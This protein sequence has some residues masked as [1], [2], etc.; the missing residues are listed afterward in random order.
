MGAVPGVEDWGI[1]VKSRVNHLLF[2]REEGP[3]IPLTPIQELLSNR[4]TGGPVDLP[5][6][7]LKLGSPHY[8]KLRPGGGAPYLGHRIVVFWG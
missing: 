7:P 8:R 1:N 2:I 6:L 3:E 5:R 4:E